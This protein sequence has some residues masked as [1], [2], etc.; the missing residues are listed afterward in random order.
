MYSNCSDEC[1]RNAER[2]LN[3]SKIL[4]ERKKYASAQSLSI[5]ALE[6]VGKAIILELVD[7]NYYDKNLA[8]K[9]VYNH[10]PKKVIMKAI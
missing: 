6:E 1:L 4:L 5:T 8:K 3:D 10:K 9:S 7:L 2:L